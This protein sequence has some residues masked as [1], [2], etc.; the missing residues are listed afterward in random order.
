MPDFLLPDLGEGLEE[1][2][3]VTWHV[4][5]GDVVTV[6]EPSGTYVAQ[7]KEVQSPDKVPDEGAAALSGQ[8]GNEQKVDVAGEFSQA[9]RQRF[10]VE[11]K[12]D[13][14]DHAF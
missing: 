5:A 10:P 11:I 9:L 2:E 12:R 4:K 7:L 3:I 1:A 6:G 8:L 13:V 14:L